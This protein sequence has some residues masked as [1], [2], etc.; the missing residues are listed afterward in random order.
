MHDGHHGIGWLG[1]RP[2]A[3]GG[4]DTP[5]LVA[6]AVSSAR[7]GGPDASDEVR[8]FATKMPM[9]NSDR[10]THC[11]G[12]GGRRQAPDR[13]TRQEGCR[14]PP[15]PTLAGPTSPSPSR[16]PSPRA[17]RLRPAPRA[18]LLRTWCA[19]TTL[20]LTLDPN[21]NPNPNQNPNQ[22]RRTGAQRH[23]RHMCGVQ[24]RGPQGEGLPLTLTLTPTLGLS[25]S[26]SLH[27]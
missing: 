24:G 18:A 10:T 7:S 3:P 16:R 12:D 4:G 13:G 1:A 14:L 25:L 17:A 2:G 23:G 19:L 26:L 22:V 5:E 27:P 15:A 8:D 6:A 20:T 9:N 11:D 21:P